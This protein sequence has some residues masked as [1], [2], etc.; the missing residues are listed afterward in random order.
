MKIV[1]A[2][3]FLYILTIIEFN[4]LNII[5]RTTYIG[6]EFNLKVIFHAIIYINRDHL[7]RES[8]KVQIT[9][10]KEEKKKKKKKKKENTCWHYGQSTFTV[11]ESHSVG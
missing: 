11:D 9:K 2:Y 1:N 5:I 7:E 4:S 8:T 3:L 10:W 6:T